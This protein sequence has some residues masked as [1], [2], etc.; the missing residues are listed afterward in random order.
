VRTSSGV[1]PATK[2]LDSRL[3][4]EVFSAIARMERLSDSQMKKARSKLTFVPQSGRQS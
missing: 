4:M 1:M 3:P 2:R